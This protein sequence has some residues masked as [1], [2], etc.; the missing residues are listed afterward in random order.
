MTD[1]LNEVSHHA[2]ADATESSKIPI[3]PLAG[4]ESENQL[5]PRL[6]RNIDSSCEALDVEP[7]RI[8]HGVHVPTQSSWLSIG[9]QLPQRS[10]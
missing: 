5:G 9:L 6:N 2:E 4:G 3:E 1:V 7:T 8:F 10:R